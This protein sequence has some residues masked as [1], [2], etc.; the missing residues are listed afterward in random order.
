MIFREELFSWTTERASP[1]V[2]LLPFQESGNALN[3]SQEQFANAVTFDSKTDS[4][5]GRQ[6]WIFMDGSGH[7]IGFWSG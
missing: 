1:E 2:S 5:T 6:Q 4:K 3:H 7:A